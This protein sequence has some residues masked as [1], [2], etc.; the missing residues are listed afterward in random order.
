MF[1]YIERNVSDIAAIRCANKIRLDLLCSIGVNG[2]KFQK[3]LFERLLTL[4]MLQ[5]A[6]P[7]Y[8]VRH[9][10][11]SQCEVVFKNLKVAWKGLKYGV[12]K[13]QYVVQ[14][15]VEAIIDST[16]SLFGLIAIGKCVGCNRR[17][18]RRAMCQRQMMD[19]QQDGEH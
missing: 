4:P 16:S 7:N 14:N 3:T 5:I 13:D 2:P 8:V 6:M 19:A 1:P 12:R 10:E 11:L 17:S 18:L 15:V 9:K